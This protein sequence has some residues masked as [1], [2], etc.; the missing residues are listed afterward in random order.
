MKKKEWKRKW[1]EENKEK[2]KEEEK[3]YRIINSEKL[4]SKR[5]EYNKSEKRVNDRRKNRKERYNNDPLYK[6]MCNIRCSISKW[7]KKKGYSKSKRTHEILGC[8]YEE[9]KIYIESKFESWMNWNNHGEYTGNYNETWQYDHIYPISM[10]NNY[11]EVLELN[12]YTKFQSLC[13]RKNYEK[14]NKIL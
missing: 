8:S 12:H 3:K 14:L 10:A 11:E 9:F 7:I 6:L 4:R 1:R 13:S 2:I 5:K